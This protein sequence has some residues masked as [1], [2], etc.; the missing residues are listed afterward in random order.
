VSDGHGMMFVGLMLF[1]V[2]TAIVAG[3]FVG[4]HFGK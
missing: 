1:V 4:V 2:A 3:L